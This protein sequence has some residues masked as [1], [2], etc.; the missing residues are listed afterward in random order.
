MLGRYTTP[1]KVKTEAITTKGINTVPSQLG[2]SKAPSDHQ[3][4]EAE[5]DEASEEDS[6]HN[7]EGCSACSV[8]RIRGTQ[9]G[10]AKLQYR[11][12]RRQLRPKH[13]KITEASPTYCFV[14]FPVHSLV[15][16]QSTTIFT[17]HS[18]SSFGEPLSSCMGLATTIGQ[19]FNF[20]PQ[21]TA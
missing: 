6:T 18:F 17:T 14:L 7:Q 16:G 4:Q 20:I 8:E 11:R 15:C 9:L 21:P 19:G 3:P 2:C 10:Y 12:K 1:A 13:G 5:G